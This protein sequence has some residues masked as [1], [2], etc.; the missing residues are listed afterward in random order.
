MVR[1]SNLGMQRQWML[2]LHGGTCSLDVVHG[3][4][5]GVSLGVLSEAN[6]T[7]ATA[8]SGI[9]V[10]HNN[11]ILSVNCLGLNVTE[12]YRLGDLAELLELGAQSAI[13]GVPCKAAVASISNA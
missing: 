2:V 8:A 3:S 13:V 6:E 4:D 11:L 9:T 1:P 12:T 5:R 10:L 7:K